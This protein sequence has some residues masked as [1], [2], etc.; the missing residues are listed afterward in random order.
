MYNATNN[1]T[2]GLGLTTGNEV[3]RYIVFILEDLYF[4]CTNFNMIY[5]V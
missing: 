2:F 1:N 3:C 5:Y 4:S